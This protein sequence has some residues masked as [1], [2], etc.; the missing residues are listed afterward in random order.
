MQDVQVVLNLSPVAGSLS[1]PHIIDDHI[2]NDG[3]AMLAMQQI[4]TERGGN[5]LGDVLVL[6][7]RQDD[8][9]GQPTHIDAVL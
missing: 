3:R 4:L 2:A 6:G 1:A 7:H 8:L 9:A 5:D